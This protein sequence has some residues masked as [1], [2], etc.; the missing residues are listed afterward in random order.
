METLLADAPRRAY[1]SLAPDYDLYTADYGYDGWLATIDRLARRHGLA[2]R[3]LLD[4]A[5]GTGR[6]FAPMRALGYEVTGCDVSPAMLERAR[7]FG[8]AELVVADM[9]ELPPLGRFELVT[10]L[11]DS[12]NYLA[13]EG[14]LRACFAGMRGNLAARGLLVFDV[15]TLLTYRTAF[16]GQAVTE[17]DGRVFLWR[18]GS[19]RDAPAGEL[20][21][22]DLDVFSSEDG[23]AWSRRTSTHVQRHFPREQVDRA[24]RAAGLEPRA[25]YGQTT[26]GE[27]HDDADESLHTKLLFVAAAPA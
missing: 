20:N 23:T 13:D 24:L 8:A 1:E 7:G 16:A 21:R 18:G 25:V 9:R 17:R 5:C 2:G 6:S 14:E 27:L 12:V 3:R 15:N 19:A 26:G 22:A 4:V 11:G 10:C